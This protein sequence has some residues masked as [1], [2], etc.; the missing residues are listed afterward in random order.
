MPSVVHWRDHSS[1]GSAMLRVLD[2]ARQA[3][4]DHRAHEARSQEREREGVRDVAFGAALTI[5]D[6]VDRFAARR[7]PRRGAPAK[8]SY[9]QC[10]EVVFRAS[11]GHS[12]LC[13]AFD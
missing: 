6:L 7:T 5:S 2:S 11:R 4:F 10:L 13:R 12:R 9:A 8:G 1:S 3:R